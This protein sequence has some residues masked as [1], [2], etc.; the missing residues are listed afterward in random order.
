MNF[1][2]AVFWDYPQFCS[3]KNLKRKLKNSRGTDIYLWIMRR[4]LEYGRV[5][6]TLKYFSLEEINNYLAELKISSYTQKKWRR[7]IEVYKKN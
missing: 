6:D 2:R 5:I 4:F 7:V 3:E 1:L